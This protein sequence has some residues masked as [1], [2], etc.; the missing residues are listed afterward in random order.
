[1]SYTFNKFITTDSNDLS[2]FVTTIEASIKTLN[3]EVKDFNSTN[4]RDLTF[5]T[6]Y[7]DL[8]LSTDGTIFSENVYADKF[9]INGATSENK[10]YLMSDGSVTTNS[11]QGQ[12]NIYLYTNS[13]GVPIDDPQSGQ[14]RLNNVSNS[15]ATHV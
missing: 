6:T 10:G 12:P 11:Q 1:M 9:V 7:I 5:K 15:S 14:V 3:N 2:E 13:N 4:L 8:P